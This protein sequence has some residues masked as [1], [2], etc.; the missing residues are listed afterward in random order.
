MRN[1]AR[2]HK[3][4]DILEENERTLRFAISVG[5]SEIV[6]PPY[7]SLVLIRET[8]RRAGRERERDESARLE[9]IAW[10]PPPR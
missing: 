8:R 2:F 4:D 6:A 5:A 3:Y 9:R 7:R 1:R 10:R